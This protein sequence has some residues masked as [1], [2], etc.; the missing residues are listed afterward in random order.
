MGLFGAAVLTMTIWRRIF[1]AEPFGASAY[2]RDYYYAHAIVSRTV[3]FP[4]CSDV[5][6]DGS[7]FLLKSNKRCAFVLR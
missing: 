6:Q 5:F 1:G 4:S 7:C 3:C 2:L